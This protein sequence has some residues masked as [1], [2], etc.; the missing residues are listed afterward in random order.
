MCF[1]FPV[2]KPTFGRKTINPAIGNTISI[3]QDFDIFAIK[4]VHKVLLK[5]DKQQTV[6]A[7]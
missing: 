4:V 5:N 6:N 2:N 7:K 3:K 1:D